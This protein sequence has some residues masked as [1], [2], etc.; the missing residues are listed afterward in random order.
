MTTMVSDTHARRTV[1]VLAAVAC[2]FAIGATAAQAQGTLTWSTPTQPD[3]APGAPL[4]ITALSCVSTSLCVA[5]DNAGQ[6][7]ATT[8]PATGGGWSAPNEIASGAVNLSGV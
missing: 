7:F 2:A 1:L 5:V 4:G 3:S 6:D 8:T